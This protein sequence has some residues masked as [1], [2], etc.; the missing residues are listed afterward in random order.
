[1]LSSVIREW[2]IF[3]ILLPELPFTL[4]PL[5]H[6]KTF[7]KPCAVFTSPCQAWPAPLRTVSLCTTSLHLKVP[8]FISTAW[9]AGQVSQSRCQRKGK[10]VREEEGEVKSAYQPSPPILSHSSLA[11]HYFPFLLEKFPTWWQNLEPTQL[12][13]V[14]GHKGGLGFSGK[15]IAHG[16]WPWPCSLSLWPSILDSLLLHL[17]SVPQGNAKPEQTGQV[18]QVLLSHPSH[19]PEKA[20]YFFS[21]SLFNLLLTALTVKPEDSSQ[22]PLVRDGEDLRT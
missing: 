21:Q 2:G 6:M 7:W 12:F 15:F 10:M 14:P 17:F 11:Q 19:A 9:E 5:K 4:V 18:K 22:C 20:T 1:M 8:D 13:S 16:L 3:L